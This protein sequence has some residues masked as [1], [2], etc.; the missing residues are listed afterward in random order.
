MNSASLAMSSQKKAPLCSIGTYLKKVNIRLQPSVGYFLYTSL[1]QVARGTGKKDSIWNRKCA[2]NVSLTFFFSFCFPPT[3]LLQKRTLVLE[4]QSTSHSVGERG[5]FFS[6][7]L[8][9]ILVLK[10]QRECL[11][12]HNFREER[13]GESRCGRELSIGGE[14][15]EETSG[16]K[17]PTLSHFPA[18]TWPCQ[19]VCVASC[20]GGAIREAPSRSED[21]CCLTLGLHWDAGKLDGIRPQVWCQEDWVV[22]QV[23]SKRRGRTAGGSGEQEPG[24]RF[25][26]HTINQ[27][28]GG[29]SAGI[30]LIRK[31][32]YV[33]RV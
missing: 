25:S 22:W 18:L 4:L 7:G 13:A 32:L 5:I 28:C 3:E 17:G 8:K 14:K 12:E 31:G 33:R 2:R 11:V 21:I 16:T 29:P 24:M 23:A 6:P 30:F 15:Q 20:T 1:L 26:P 19:W 27:M 10:K 9:C